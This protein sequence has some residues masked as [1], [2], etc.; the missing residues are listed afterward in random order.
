MGGGHDVGLRV[1]RKSR[2][3]VGQSMRKGRL[4]MVVMVATLDVFM[5]I[6]PL[7][8]LSCLGC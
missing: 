6:R 7:I 2:W 1:G 4:E 5:Q 8:L 3:V